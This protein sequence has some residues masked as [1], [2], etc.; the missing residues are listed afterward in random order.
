MTTSILRYIYDNL[1]ICTSSV[2]V[3]VF[4]TVHCENRNCVRH[5]VCAYHNF[6]LPLPY[7]PIRCSSIIHVWT[8]VITTHCNSLHYRKQTDDV[9][10]KE[11]TIELTF[12]AHI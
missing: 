10:Q 4:K 11:K 1:C 9:L 3:G 6:L 5:S 8:C 7:A 2:A 12:S